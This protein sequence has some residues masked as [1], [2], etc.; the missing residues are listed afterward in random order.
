MD[1]DIAYRK[2]QQHTVRLITK[3]FNSIS[4]PKDTPN[5]KLC[6]AVRDLHKIDA[7]IIAGQEPCIDFKQKGQI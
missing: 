6:N 5:V 4:T 3:N 2:T 1:G 7:E